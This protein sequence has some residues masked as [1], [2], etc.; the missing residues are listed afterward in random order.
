MDKY[1]EGNKAAWEEAFDYRDASW[2]ADITDRIQKEDYPFFNKETIAALQ[3]MH[4]EER[5]RF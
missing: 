5:D 3:I 2:G 4:T 1:I